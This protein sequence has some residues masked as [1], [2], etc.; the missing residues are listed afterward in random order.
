[1]KIESFKHKM[2]AH[3]ETGAITASLNYRGLEISEPMVFGIG[4]GI[5]FGYFKNPRFTFPIFTVRSR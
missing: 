3:C 1:M 4:S 5:F 2:A